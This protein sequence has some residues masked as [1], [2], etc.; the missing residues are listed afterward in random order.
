MVQ[1]QVLF[2]EQIIP[3]D[4]DWFKGNFQNNVYSNVLFP[5]RKPWKQL[6]VVVLGIFG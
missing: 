6:L 2:P 3:P 4:T 5:A 1:T